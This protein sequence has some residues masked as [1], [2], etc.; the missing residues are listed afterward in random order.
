[1]IARNLFLEGLK[2][3]SEEHAV[4]L[5]KGAGEPTDG[6]AREFVKLHGMDALGRVAKLHFKN[7]RKLRV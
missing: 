7:T 3:L 6:S 2:A 4:H 1:M 5:H